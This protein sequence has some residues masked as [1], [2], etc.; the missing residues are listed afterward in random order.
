MSSLTSYL[1]KKGAVEPGALQRVLLN[2]AIR[3]GGIGV[4]LLEASAI[5]EH[6]LVELT[7]RFHRL[8]GVHTPECLAADP[9]VV[10][11][12]SAGE[13]T[14]LAAVPVRRSE[15]EVLLA[16]VEPLGR[17]ELV[18]LERR[19]GTRV[20]MDR[21]VPRRR[22]AGAGRSARAE[23]GE[24]PRHHPAGERRGGRA[25]IDGGHHGR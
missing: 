17:S 25:P 4:N 16:C 22:R 24:D 7:S 21:R 20:K 12:L 6:R 14:E 9:D 11:S 18:S 3:G 19:W 1:A 10:T 5:E 13:A 23:G 15:G 2:Q 8:P